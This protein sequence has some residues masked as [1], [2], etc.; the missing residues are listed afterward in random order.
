MKKSTLLLV[1]I[2]AA[3][4]GFVYWHEFVRVPKQQ[5]NKTNPAVFH[6]QPE[7][8]ASLTLTRPEV[9][10]VIQRDGSTWQIVAPVK[11]RANKS[12]VSSLLDDV[13]LARS[14]RSLTPSG[15][16][17]QVFGLATPAATLDFRLKDGKQHR[18][19]VG[20]QDYNGQQAYARIGGSKQ[21]IL[22]PVSVR[23]D[24][25]KTLGDLRD[26]SVLGISNDDVK[27]FTLKSPAGDVEAARSASGSDW[28][29]E[30]PK[31]LAGDSVAISQLLT[32]VSSAK[33]AKIV[34]ENPASLDRYGLAHPAISFEAHLG[35]GGDRTLSL[36]RKQDGQVFARDSSREMVF[37]VP[38][39]L[40]TQ[41]R[42]S[43]FALRDKR[44][45]HS[46]PEDFSQVDYRAGSVHFSF[47]VDKKGK[48][49]VFAP[50]A[51]KGKPVANWKVFDPLSSA[52]ATAIF[53]SPPASLMAKVAHPAIEITL[54][55]TDGGKKIFRISRP[56][57]DH[58]YVWISDATGIYQLAKSSID[59]LTFHG[60][61][62]ILR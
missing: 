14:S 16:Q 54:T 21:A 3:L 46:L 26:N 25:L 5:N 19:L 43:L 2:A 10:I 60:V 50:A 35:A 48:W 32:H 6:F 12:A 58:V 37:L 22:V 17:L 24:A 20:A 62:D 23:Q 47:G 57:G 8:V 38:A 39:D 45:L 61:K 34:S 41:L 31:K 52:N 33:I 44:L 18:L 13:T 59:S 4:G 27:S 30:Q 56:E 7:D 55:R 42:L 51:E 36:G 28:S 53:N 40:A 15:N 1:L 49:T 29:I 11:T 9:N